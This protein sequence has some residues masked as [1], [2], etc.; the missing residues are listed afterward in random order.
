MGTFVSVT[1]KGSQ[2]APAPTLKPIACACVSTL[3]AIFS[4]YQW[5]ELAELNLTLVGGAGVDEPQGW[6][7]SVSAT[8]SYSD[9]FSG[10]PE[11]ILEKEQD[12]W[13]IWNFH[14]TVPPA[15]ILYKPQ[16]T[17]SIRFIDTV[18][19]RCYTADD[20]S[21]LAL[22]WRL[23]A[24]WAVLANPATRLDSDANRLMAGLAA[25]RLAFLLNAPGSGIGSRPLGGDLWTISLPSVIEPA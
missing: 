1:Q 3:L 16:Q 17:G 14:V 20:C 4:D 13:R 10:T 7:A 18:G 23:P 22:P 25:M 21:S 11:A 12:A 19:C 5:I 24:I 8:V 2:A 15:K 6:V 9:G